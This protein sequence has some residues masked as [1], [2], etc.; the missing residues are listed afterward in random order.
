MKVTLLH[1][2]SFQRLLLATT[3]F[4]TELLPPFFS[5]FGLIDATRILSFRCSINFLTKIAICPIVQVI[6]KEM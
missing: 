6:I 3:E 4:D 1:K 2:Y 5:R